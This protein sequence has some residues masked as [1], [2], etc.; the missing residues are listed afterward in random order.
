M[1][2]ERRLDR[3][4]V[5]EIDE[6]PVHELGFEINVHQPNRVSFHVLADRLNRALKNALGR[7]LTLGAF[8]VVHVELQIALPQG[9]VC[10]VVSK[11]SFKDLLCLFNLVAFRAC[12]L[13]VLRVLHR[14]RHTL[15]G[16]QVRVQRYEV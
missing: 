9:N 14:D 5:Q 13:V 3:H 10:R 7:R 11:R 1:L 12:L 15:L 4:E 16:H 6:A 8:E 2:D